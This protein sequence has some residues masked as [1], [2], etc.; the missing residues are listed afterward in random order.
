M[1]SVRDNLQIAKIQFALAGTNAHINHDLCLAIDATCK[2]TNTVQLV[3][4][5]RPY[6]LS[7]LPPGE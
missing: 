6:G 3:E 4:L 5:A 1:F 7:L 2:A